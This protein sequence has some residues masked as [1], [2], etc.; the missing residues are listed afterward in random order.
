MRTQM[1]I[2]LSM[3]VFSFL[4][5]GIYEKENIKKNG[6]PLLLKLAPV[7]PRSLM[8]GDYMQLRY[9]IENNPLLATLS[10]QQKRGYIVVRP[11]EQN[12]A[13]FVRFYNDEEL[14]PGEKLLHYRQRFRRI[15]IVP[16]AFFFQEGHAKQYAD[17]QYGIFKFDDPKKYLLVGLADAHGTPISP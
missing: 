4:N 16:D 17:A 5:Y 6:T 13:Q 14:A 2:V 12:I 1:M 3:L 9:A 7:D 15:H 10:A 8:Q 11:D